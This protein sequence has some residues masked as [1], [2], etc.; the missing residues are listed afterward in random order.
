MSCVP[1][2]SPAI[3]PSSVRPA[4]ATTTAL[5][6]PA[7]TSEPA[8]TMLD[9]SPMLAVS[10]TSLSFLSTGVDSP[11]SIASAVCRLRE[12]MTRMSAAMRSP[13]CINTT[14]P[15]TSSAVETEAR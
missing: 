7:A 4:V 8:K 6:V 11:V 1:C 5:P 13:A 12:D 9:R 15:G 2:K 3:R 14:S 10:A